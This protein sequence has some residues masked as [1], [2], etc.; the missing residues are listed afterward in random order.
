MPSQVAGSAQSTRSAERTKRCIR[1]TAWATRI[2]AL[3]SIVFCIVAFVTI[4]EYVFGIFM[5]VTAIL[6]V[7]SPLNFNCCCYSD[8]SR[9]TK[10]EKAIGHWGVIVWMFLSN[11]G[12]IVMFGYSWYYWMA[13]RDSY[14]YRGSRYDNNY[15]KN[16][17]YYYPNH[18][19]SLLDTVFA[20]SLLITF[21]LSIFNLYSL[22][23]VYKYG[24][25]F[26]NEVDKEH[27]QQSVETVVVMNQQ[28]ST[29]GGGIPVNG[30]QFTN[31]AVGAQQ[32]F[33]NPG[34]QYPQY[35]PYPAGPH[36]MATPLPQ[37]V[38]VTT[39]SVG[40][41]FPPTMAEPVGQASSPPPY[42]EADPNEK[43]PQ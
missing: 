20:M 39:D 16:Y 10:A 9:N 22:C 25:C 27:S 24:C 32:P 30:V 38:G 12:Y 3:L 11:I 17:S 7:M 31:A 33:T 19:I 15:N 2:L 5:M 23:L 35:Q 42:A 40:V 43:Q 4:G 29:I 26:M 18:D 37:A 6:S 34:M 13:S 14:Y 1:I 21:F 28:I 41:S 8:C 36:Y